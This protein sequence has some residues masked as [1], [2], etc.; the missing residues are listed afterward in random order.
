MAILKKN[1]RTM[2]VQ[3]PNFRDE[4]ST[5]HFNKL[6]QTER[7]EQITEHEF[8]SSIMVHVSLRMPIDDV[9]KIKTAAKSLGIGHTAFIRMILHQ[10]VSDF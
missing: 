2:E 8:D 7:T 5:R 3:V 1:L 9:N 10:I 6:C 4:I